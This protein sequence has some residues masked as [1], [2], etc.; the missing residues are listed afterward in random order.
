MLSFIIPAHNEERLLGAT[1]DAIHHAALVSGQP[2]EVIVVDD[3][4]TDQTA[5]VAARHR[6][7]VVQVAHR[8]IAATRNS[9]AAVA[10]GDLLFF[11]DAD[12]R[13]NPAVISDAIAAIQ[14]G[15]VAGGAAITFDEPIPFYAR[16]LTPLIV[17]SFRIGQLAAGCF[18]FSTRAAFFAAG[19]FSEAHFAAEEIFISRALRRQ[20]KFV[21]L[22]SAVLTSGRKLRT[23]SAKELLGSMLKLVRA[24]PKSVQRREGLDI[25]YGERRDDLPR[26][27]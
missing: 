26:D 8:Q 1:I 18:V 16:L 23:Y 12:T 15:A 27:D 4:S 13:V 25:W 10:E 3:A 19:G 6:A 21:V 24:G 11:V 2:H 20:G 22:R 5:A 9:G 17:L 7:S 14:A